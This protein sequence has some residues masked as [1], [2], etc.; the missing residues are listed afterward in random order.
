[1]LYPV[2]NTIANISGILA[3][4]VAGLVLGDDTSKA[5][6]A[7]WQRVFFI[8]GGM[9]AGALVLWA[10]FMRGKPVQALN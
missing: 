10:A 4:I 8:T 2:G 7:E 9:Y 1:M 5:G 6:K 3:P